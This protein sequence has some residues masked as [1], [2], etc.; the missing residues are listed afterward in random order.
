MPANAQAVSVVAESNLGVPF[1]LVLVDPS[2]LTLQTV[3]ASSGL[4]TINRAVT[5]GG[6]YAIKVINLGVGSIQVST[7]TTPLVTR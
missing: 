3:N 4:A 2:G 6:I 5:P 1:Q 7:T